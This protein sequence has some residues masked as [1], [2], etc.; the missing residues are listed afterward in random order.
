MRCAY[1]PFSTG[2]RVCLGASFAMQE[3]VLILATLVRHFEFKPVE[4][5]IPEP[6]ARLTLRSENGVRLHIF[7]REDD[8]AA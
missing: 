6:I 5:H 3:G 8:A 4:G 7:P 2:P 1:L